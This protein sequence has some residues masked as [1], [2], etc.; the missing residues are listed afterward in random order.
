MYIIWLIEMAQLRLCIACAYV[1]REWL[2]RLACWTSV[3]PVRRNNSFSVC[4][5]LAEWR[6]TITH[7]LYLNQLN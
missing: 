4:T 6:W 7:L 5:F 1:Q 3:F 2:A